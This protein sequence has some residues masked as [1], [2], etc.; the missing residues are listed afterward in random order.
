MT[1]LNTFPHL[2]VK[3][4]L[5]QR[6]VFCAFGR[7]LGDYPANFTPIQAKVGG[8][9]CWAEGAPA[10]IGLH[11]SLFSVHAGDSPHLTHPRVSELR[12]RV[13]FVSVGRCWGEVRKMRSA[14]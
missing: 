5:S 4:F 11:R 1:L 10:L 8:A 9:L 13:A 14:R 2:C 3:S 7:T 12:L 6:V